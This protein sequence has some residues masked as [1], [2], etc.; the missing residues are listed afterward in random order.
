[1]KHQ[2][3]ILNRI[4]RRGH[5]LTALDRFLLGF[6]SLFLSPRHIQRAAVVVRPSTLLKFHSMLK[7][8]KY[9]LPYSS[10]D[11]K[12]KPGP[13]SPSQELIKVIVEMK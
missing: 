10:T 5:Y 8:W 7:Q 13:K 12:Q 6:W 11:S 2:F 9:R 1:M 3:V 4:R